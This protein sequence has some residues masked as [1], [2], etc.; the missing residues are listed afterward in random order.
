MNI[1]AMRC[2]FPHV[3]FYKIEFMQRTN[4]KIH[5]KNICAAKAT[6]KERDRNRDGE[7]N[8]PDCLVVD[9]ANK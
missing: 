6:E 2:K 3:T 9:K 1:Y 4:C 5:W 8:V 7:S